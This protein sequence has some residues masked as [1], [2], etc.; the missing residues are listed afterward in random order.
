[1]NRVKVNYYG[2]ISPKLSGGQEESVCLLGEATVRDL[3]DLLVAKHGDGFKESLLTSDGQLQ[4][5]TRI[6]YNDCDINAINGLD[7]RLEDNSELSITVM[8]GT[9]PGG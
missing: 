4:M 3:F 6:Y 7:T 2:V 5:V 8:P 9:I 1:M